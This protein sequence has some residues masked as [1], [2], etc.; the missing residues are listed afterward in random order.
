MSLVHNINRFQNAVSHSFHFGELRRGFLFTPFNKVETITEGAN[1]YKIEYYPNQQKAATT[2]THNNTVIEHKYYAGKAFEWETVNDK[3]YYYV[4]AEGQPIAVFIQDGD[5]SPVP[6]LIL[7][8]HLGSVDLITD[9]YGNVVDSMSFDAW[10]NRRNYNDWLL[11]DNTVHLIDRGFTMH[12]HLDSFNL[13]NMEG[14]MYDPVVAQFL[15]PDPYI[16]IPDNTQGLNRYNYCYNSPLMYSDPNGETPLFI[17]AGII[18]SI[19]GSYIGASNANNGQYNFAQW[20]WKDG[21]TYAGMFIGGIA[22][23][24]TGA[25]MIAGTSVGSS[26]IPFANTLSTGISSL[27]FSGGMSVATLGNKSPS[28]SLGVASYDFGSGE[29][30]YL[31][32]KGNEWYE[33]MAYAF[34]AMANLTDVVSLFGGGTNYNVNSSR[35]NTKQGDEWWGHSSGTGDGIDISVGPAKKGWGNP[36]TYADYMNPNAGGVKWYNY[37]NDE[38]TWSI[39]LNNVNQKIL[40]NMTQNIQNGKGL[41]W[42]N[43]KWNLAG[44]SCVNYV[45]RSLWA[46]GIPTLP[47]NLHPH[48][49]NAQLLIRQLGIYSS[50]YLYN[51]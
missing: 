45:S 33:D 19:I 9:R 16:Q 32:K 10:G 21:T 36:P 25:G 40:Q 24:V 14:R 44:Y 1:N 35:T 48:I 17:V 31:G 39:E 23:F 13:I 28:V 46:T 38:G 50:P 15:S 30:G 12:Q 41:F 26:S 20:N 6:Y 8:D 22:G 18:G 34:G 42:G 27:N 7:T 11:K 29:W 49:L 51:F 3:K 47:I 2:L 4:Y 5:D 43:L 37:A